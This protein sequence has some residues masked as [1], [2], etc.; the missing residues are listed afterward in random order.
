MAGAI[1]PKALSF[2]KSRDSDASVA[3]VSMMKAVAGASKAVS[4]GSRIHDLESYLLT[5]YRRR[6]S[7]EIRNNDREAQQTSALEDVNTLNV[8]SRDV[9]AQMERNVLLKEI[10][11]RMDAESRWIYEKLILGYTYEEMAKDKRMK[12]KNIRAN[13]L[14]SRF[15]KTLKRIAT[16]VNMKSPE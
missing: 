3:H 4:S 13:V 7:R 1:W 8:A 2:A 11:R 15:S 5:A 10:V 6:L 16:E 14:R 9:T 12:A